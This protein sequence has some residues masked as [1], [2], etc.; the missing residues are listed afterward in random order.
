MATIWLDAARYSD[1]YG[2]QVD[3]DRHVWPWRD[4]VV[5]AFNSNMPFDRFT[6]LQLAGDLLPNASDDD[7]LATTFN[8]LHPQKVEGGSTPEE[9]RIEYVADRNHTFG[10]AFLGLALE[11]ARC[12]E[13]KYDPISQ[14]EYYELFA[15]FNNIDEAGLYSYFTPATPTPTLL[16]ATDDVKRRLADFDNRVGA[17][18]QTLAGVAEDREEQFQQWLVERTP[19]P[20]TP[21]RIR[22]EDFETH[23]SGANKRVDGVIGAAIQF[24]GDDAFGVGVGN[25]RRHQPFSVA[26]WLKTPDVKDRA[27]VFHRS[28]AWTD[29]GS[30]GYQLLLEDGRL[31]ASL[32]HFWPGNAIRVRAVRPLPVNEWRHVVVTYDG[33]SRA[34]GLRLYAQGKR[35]EAKIVR[36]NLYKNITGGGGDTISLGARFRDRGFTGGAVDEF[37]VYD[38]ELTPLEAAQLHD[39]ES[40]MNALEAPIDQLNPVTLANLRA[41]YLSTTDEKYQSQLDALAKLRSERNAAGDGVTEIMVMRELS[42]RRETFVL[43]RGSY[44]APMEPVEPGTPSAFPPF[45]EETPR[46]RLGLAQWLTRDDHP[47]TARVTMNRLWQQCFGV[48]LVRSPEDF[49]SQGTP[50]THPDLLNWLSRDLIDSG[51]DVKRMLKKIVLSHAYR[52]SSTASSELLKRDP[53]NRLL[54]RG[55]RHR[56]PAEMI[57][58]NALFVSGL[59]AQRRGG[60]PSKPYEVAVSFKPV[61]RDKGDGLYRRSLYT[62]WKRTAPAPVMM[63]LDA[64]KRDVCNVKRERTSSPLQAL[65]LLNDPQLVESA[66]VLAQRLLRQ[67]GDD[68][69]QLI[70]AMFVT[71][72]SRH[73]AKRESELLRDLLVQ[74]TEHYADHGEAAQA[75]LKVGDAVADKGLPAAR[76][77]AAAIVANTLLNYDECI[78]KR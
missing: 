38:R 41:Y 45:G 26:L 52:Q 7:I 65:V 19:T 76:L 20:W 17:A 16:M 62:Y 72:T 44:A 75:L 35:V 46:N 18:E 29:A 10:T 48:G 33:S 12:H 56:L 15:F 25:F 47:L 4:W 77:A 43:R 66:R 51:W 69:E 3:R 32:I 11:C 49:G 78:M 67:H 55:P 50:P 8:R 73:P 60:P 58:D 27:V 31:S 34:A 13:H 54:A 24:S 30:R 5:R 6:T 1:T 14:R 71:L 40:L 53:D 36:D 22:L 28:R 61:G 23:Q 9:F 63:A 57:R 37:S 59:L 2:Y 39:G 21:R 74:Q 64:S 68:D 42:P 70:D